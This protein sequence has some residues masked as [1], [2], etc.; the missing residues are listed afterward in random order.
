MRTFDRRFGSRWLVVEGGYQIQHGVRFFETNAVRVKAYEGLWKAAAPSRKFTMYFWL[1]VISFFIFWLPLCA[2]S[3]FVQH[4][5]FKL[6]E[7]HH[8]EKWVRLGKPRLY[9]NPTKHFFVFWGDVELDADPRLH[10][11]WQLA[12][13]VAWVA[14]IYCA[15]IVILSLAIWPRGA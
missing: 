2:V 10:P 1:L 13:I 14:V 3:W 4:K 6:L 15:A 8:Y 12:R 7:Q 9:K 11:Y 5:L